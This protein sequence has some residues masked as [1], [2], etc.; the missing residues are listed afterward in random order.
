M[1]KVLKYVG[2]PLFVL[3]LASIGVWAHTTG[4]LI[5]QDFIDGTTLKGSVRYAGNN[6]PGSQYFGML[7]YAADFLSFWTLN[8]TDIIFY[9]NSSEA[10]RLFSTGNIVFKGSGQSGD[11]LANGSVTR[12]FGQQR[13]TT[14]NTAGVGT[15]FLAGGATSGATDKDGGAVTLLPGQSTGVGRALAYI[16]GYATVTGSGAAD[17]PQVHRMVMNGYKT[18]S[19]NVTTD[20]VQMTLANNSAVA[21]MVSYGVEVFD[22]TDIQV[23]EGR[24]VCHATN[25]GGVLANNVCA[26]SGNQ[27]ALTAGTQTVTFTITAANP[28]V[29]RVNSDSSLVPTSIKFNYT[30]TN[31]ASQQIAVQ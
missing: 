6:A 9:V 20:L 10:L 12:T 5:N 22:G 30:F 1:K 15:A 25:K 31:L 14:A 18:L 7:N 29:V 13:H 28:A 2:I 21:A 26:K 3:F 4:Q 23:E 27:Q 19:D 8:A 11:I 24:V 17:N 16:D